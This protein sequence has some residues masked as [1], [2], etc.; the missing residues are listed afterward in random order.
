V[1][2]IRSPRRK[3]GR[4]SKN[5]GRV[6]GS[7]S[8]HRARIGREVSERL[9]RNPQVKRAK[10]EAAQMYTYPN[11]LSDAECDTLIDLIQSNSRPSTL[12]ATSDD[13]EYR[14]SSS[15]DLYRWSDEVR[16]VDLRI[17]ELLGIPEENAETLQG[18]RYE[19]N[20]QF[21]A[22]CDYFH[23]TSDY[24]PKMK[25]T[26][27]Q[28]TWTAMA[29]LNDVEEGGATWF[30]RA[31]IRFKPKRGTLVIWNNMGPDGTPNYDTLHEG[32]RVV[33][34]TKF[35]VTKWFREQAWIKDYVPTYR[36][37]G[38]ENASGD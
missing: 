12:L 29:Y 38:L 4:V 2:A 24:W 25:E 28:R 34:G 27:G 13:P 15:S 22:H 35:I 20:Q 16:T 8:P 21:R 7:P 32:M 14:T 18:Q 36:A 33:E 9:E 31:G 30:P 3:F 1:L 23:E 11:F 5:I 6:S 37:G 10:T 17:A 26:G 19:V